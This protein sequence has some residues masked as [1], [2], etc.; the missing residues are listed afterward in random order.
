MPRSALTGRSVGLCLFFFAL[1]SALPGWSCSSRALCRSA[2]VAPGDRL[3]RERE[4]ENVRAHCLALQLLPLRPI[5]LSNRQ[6]DSRS[7]LLPPFAGS[8][9]SGPGRACSSSGL[10]D[11]DRSSSFAS[12][13]PF[14]AS[15]APSPSPSPRALASPPSLAVPS[16]PFLLL[17]NLLPPMACL[18]VLEPVLSMHACGTSSFFAFLELSPSLF[19]YSAE[20]LKGSG[21]L[22]RSHRFPVNQPRLPISSQFY[23]RLHRLQGGGWRCPINEARL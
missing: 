11:F 4:R 15:A 9:W 14:P 8:A 10:L 3:L 7:L 22:G 5:Y 12:F 2:C 6:T 21:L 20:Q 18:L 23:S 13:P 19:P 16:L 1:C 17:L